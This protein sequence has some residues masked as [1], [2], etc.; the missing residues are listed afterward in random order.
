MMYKKL[1]G[2]V[3]TLGVITSL[4]VN[5][6]HGSLPLAVGPNGGFASFLSAGVLPADITGIL[7]KFWTSPLCAGVSSA[8]DAILA[9]T[10]TINSGST[11][12]INQVNLEFN[13][14]S[15]IAID[16]VLATQSIQLAFN[17]STGAGTG[18]LCIEIQCTTLGGAGCSYSGAPVTATFL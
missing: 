1:K 9:G 5:A 15:S 17:T 18:T 3:L 7:V 13:L 16:P 11:T 6:T 8:D 12:W 10:F 2:F 4:H 14:Y